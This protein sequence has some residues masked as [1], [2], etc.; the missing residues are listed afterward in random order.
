MVTK[1]IKVKN[2]SI[3]LPEELRRLWQDAEVFLSGAKDTILI[4]RMSEPRL[5]FR[6][7]LD[8][9]NRIGKGVSR[10]DVKEAI[11]AVRRRK[12]RS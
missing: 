5:S 3:P 9:F 1:T 7:M 8:E 12:E 11:E 10:K 4:K 2:G 6:A